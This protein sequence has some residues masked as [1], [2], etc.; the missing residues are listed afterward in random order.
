MV[1][2]YKTSFVVGSHVTFPGFISITL[3]DAPMDHFGGSSEIILF[4]FTRVRGARIYDLSQCPMEDEVLVPPPSVHRIASVVKLTGYLLLTLES[5]VSHLAYIGAASPALPTSHP[6]FA[7]PHA[8]PAVSTVLPTSHSALARPHA[9]PA[10]ST[11]LPTSHSALA[12]PH[13]QP[14][15]L[16]MWENDDGTAFREFDPYDCEILEQAMQRGM[17]TFTHP[18]RPWLFDL[19]AMVQTNVNSNSKRAIKRMAPQKLS[20][21]SASSSAAAVAS[22][23][24]SSAQPKTSGIAALRVPQV[25]ASDVTIVPHSADIKGGSGVVRQVMFRGNF[26]AMKKPNMTLTLNA[27]DRAKFVKELEITYAVRHTACVQMLGACVDAGDMFLLLEWMEGGSLYDALGNHADRPVLPRVRLSI[28]RNVADGLE[29]LHSCGIVHRDIKS[30]NILLTSDMRAKVCD[31]GLATL[32][33]LTSSARATGGGGAAGTY[34]WFAPEL[35]QGAKSNEKSDIYAFGVVLWELLTCD[36]PF[37]GLTETQVRGLLEQGK[38]PEIPQPLPEGFP[39]EFVSLICSCWDQSP[40]LRPTAQQALAALISMD[41]KSHINGPVQLYPLGYSVPP[42]STLL[43]LLTIA[44]PDAA[45]LSLLQQICSHV[46]D[47]LALHQRFV[48]GASKY[49]L[50]ALEAYCIAAYTCD[51]RSFGR[52]REDSPFFMYAHNPR[53]LPPPFSCVS[54]L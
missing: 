43:S 1:D 41:P 37:D 23:S 25:C 46:T 5:V 22:A 30:L 4:N 20:P 45:A 21:S 13:A 54:I 26:A 24:I 35:F 6:A 19:V 32:Q 7:R 27:R 38:R 49:G 8:Q 15:V 2:S 29:Y 34:P 3:G 52:S 53:A 40:E 31:F 10:V 11:V 39:P 9:Q 28:A 51:A 16:W 12:R 44:M 33:T 47:K 14:A 48:D 50:S 36:V 18:N 17:R 42:H